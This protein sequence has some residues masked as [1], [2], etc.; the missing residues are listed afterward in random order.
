MISKICHMDYKIINKDTLSYIHGKIAEIHKQVTKEVLST[1]RMPKMLDNYDVCKILGI[2][3][4]TLQY[5]RDKD[6]LAFTM[7]HGKCLYKEEDILK[8]VEEH[9]G[10]VAKTKK[11]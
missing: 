3:L 7:F 8:F 5:Y 4:R 2:S 6:L 1:A 11:K 9:K 10:K